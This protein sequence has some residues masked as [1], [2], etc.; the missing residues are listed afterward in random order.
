ML[1]CAFGD[2]EDNDAEKSCPNYL[3]NAPKLAQAQIKPLSC[4]STISE[5][6]FSEFIQ[7]KKN[8]SHLLHPQWV[9]SLGKKETHP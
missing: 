5:W 9:C 7:K 6:L 8:L 1:G 3:H 4:L 2:N